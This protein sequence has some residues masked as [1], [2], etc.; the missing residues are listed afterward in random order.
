MTI[1]RDHTHILFTITELIGIDRFRCAKY[2]AARHD[3]RKIDER[4]RLDLSR[5][6]TAGLVPKSASGY[7]VR[8]CDLE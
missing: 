3:V 1:P 5:L 4:V 8:E 6:L 7:I 2:D